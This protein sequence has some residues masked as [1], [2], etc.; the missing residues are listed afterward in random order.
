MP[1]ASGGDDVNRPPPD[2]NSSTC[3]L[4]VSGDICPPSPPPR[5]RAEPAAR[6]RGHGV[7]LT[8]SQKVDHGRAFGQARQ[9]CRSRAWLTGE[10]TAAGV[11]FDFGLGISDLDHSVPA[12]PN[13]GIIDLL[14]PAG[15]QQP[16]GED[17]PRSA[18]AT[19]CAFV[20]G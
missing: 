19:N 5:R 13:Q 8:R 6:P 11:V 17:M 7:D 16:V 2:W 1:M 18:S 12:W 14:A 10:R 15:V 9:A 20:D 4:R 3:L